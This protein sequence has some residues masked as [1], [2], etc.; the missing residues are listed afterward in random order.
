MHSHTTF[1]ST[2]AADS[3]VLWSAGSSCGHGG[4]QTIECVAA[5]SAER[6]SVGHWPKL[7]LQ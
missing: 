2:V 7:E 1:G 6:E 4:C 5:R 3:A